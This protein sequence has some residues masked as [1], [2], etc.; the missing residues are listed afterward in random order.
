MTD[1][2]SELE[3]LVSASRA[4]DAEPPAEAGARI[5]SGVVASGGVGGV[6]PALAA[7]S[8]LLKIGLAVGATLVTAG[9]ITVAAVGWP[10]SARDPAAVA[11]PRP[12]VTQP[13]D[14]VEPEPAPA[15]PSV[16][17]EDEPE[18]VIDDDDVPSTRGRSARSRSHGATEPAVATEGLAEETRLLRAA[19]VALGR[20]DARAARAKLRQHAKRFPQGELVEVRMALEVEV[21]CA[22]G[23]TAEAEGA[24][25]RFLGRYPDSAL[26]GRVRARC[27]EG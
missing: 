25:S 11:D 13:R 24:A 3:R 17:P 5:W 20:G 1:A 21:L 2:T 8:S 14:P 23:R 6:A 26:A 16:E 9:T 18:L 15:A 10:G 27:A 12:A 19:K 4:L 7:S 22:L